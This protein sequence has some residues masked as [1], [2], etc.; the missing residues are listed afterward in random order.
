MK[1]FINILLLLI[2][3]NTFGQKSAEDF[4]YRYFTTEFKKDTIHIIVK[5]KKGEE[6]IKK[7]IFIFIQGSLAKPVLK[8]NGNKHFPPFP[9]SSNILEDE[10]HIIVINKPGIPFISDIADLEKNNE[11]IDKLT[12]LPPAEYLEKNNLDYFVE[13]DNKVIEY[14]MKQNWVDSSKIVVAGHSEGSTIAV[15]LAEANQNV[16]QL[17][18]SGGTPYYSRI[19]SIISQDRATESDSTNWVEKDFDYWKNTTQNRFDISRSHGYNTY[20]GTYSFS[21]NL[22]YTF[23]KLKIPILVSYGTKDLAC[24]YVDLLQIEMIENKKNNID[25]KA[26]LGLEHNYFPLNTDG[27]INYDEFNWDKVASDWK[28][29]LSR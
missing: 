27:S 16:T 29:W 15:K 24:P 19:A 9:F 2:S 28:Q 17:I 7:P 20:K 18:Y 3:I 11:F 22:S 23:K 25:F 6:K 26:Y 5:S 13:R 4:G 1:I 8:Y 10:Y 14:L 12:D 21:E